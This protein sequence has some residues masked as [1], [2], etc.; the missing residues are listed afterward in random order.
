MRSQSHELCGLPLQHGLPYGST[1]GHR[2]PARTRQVEIL[3]SLANDLVEKYGSKTI[4]TELCN[5]ELE[6]EVFWDCTTGA[7]RIKR[8][9]LSSLAKN[10]T[11]AGH[12]QRPLVQS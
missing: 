10:S 7:L 6:L 9:A 5:T 2:T 11:W 4:A 1:Q 8:S 3:Q 12:T